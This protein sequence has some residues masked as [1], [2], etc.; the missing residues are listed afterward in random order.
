M[1]KIILVMTTILSLS[2]FAETEAPTNN[3]VEV[4]RK[5][6]LENRGDKSWFFTFEPIGLGPSGVF[7]QGLNLGL[8]LS[9]RS[10]LQV[11]L[12]DGHNYLH[13]DFLF[14]WGD[15][16]VMDGFSAGVYL[17]RFVSN[18][19]YTKGGI[20]YRTIDYKHTD[21]NN[22]FGLSNNPDTIRSFSGESGAVS[23]AIGN[24]WQMQN[25]TIGCDWF[26]VELPFASR[27]YNVSYSNADESTRRDNRADFRRYV[28][29]VNYTFTRLYFGASF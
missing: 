4:P 28:T 6:S 15:K 18:S 22:I 2:A 20:D 25:F 17:K 24:Q 8:F 29:S 27:V 21:D 23:L 7:A 11:E 9:D 13:D 10:L 26:G 14:D 19:F 1:K 5:T 12:N 3:E 16:T